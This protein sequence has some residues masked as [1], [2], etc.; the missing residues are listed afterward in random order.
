[1]WCWSG[2]GW[3]RAGGGCSIGPGIYACFV[4]G[5][6]FCGAT[7]ISGTTNIFSCAI[8]IFSTTGRSGIYRTSATGTFGTTGIPGTPC[9]TSCAVNIA[10]SRSFD[11]VR[12]ENRYLPYP[13][14]INLFPG[15][16]SVG[17]VY[18]E[19]SGD[20]SA[21]GCRDEVQSGFGG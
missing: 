17:D 19:P 10:S 2:P 21:R 3:G 9:T 11:P 7:G 16:K 8:S 4:G 15:R 20:L 6:I 13:W 12:D 14:Q 18:G 5:C 1:L